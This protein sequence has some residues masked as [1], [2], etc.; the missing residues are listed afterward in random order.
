MT[1]YFGRVRGPLIMLGLA[2]AVTSAL[3]NPP[4]GKGKGKHNKGEAVD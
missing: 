4:E 1:K 2:L 3:A